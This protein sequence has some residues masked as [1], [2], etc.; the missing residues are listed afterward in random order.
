[1]FF[2]VI[3]T[4]IW[5]ARNFIDIERVYNK[6]EF[7]KFEKSKNLW[8]ANENSKEE[9]VVVNR[10]YYRFNNDTVINFDIW[11][12]VDLHK[13]FWYIKFN[14]KLKHLK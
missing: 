9:F 5:S 2:L 7:F 13:L 8:I 11:T 6:L 12:L 4:S 1:M 14:R 3:I 10:N